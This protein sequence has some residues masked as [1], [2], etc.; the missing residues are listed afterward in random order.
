MVDLGP[1]PVDHWSLAPEIVDT[2]RSVEPFTA[3]ADCPAC[4][5]V[6]IHRLT[7]PHQEPTGDEPA[8]R[9]RRKIDMMLMY[10]GQFDERGR[11]ALQE[12]YDPPEATVARVCN[13]CGYRWGQR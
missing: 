2:D 10:M 3:V 9:V 4:G 13:R 7:E 8:D 6:G 12:P 1:L 5:N 11:Y